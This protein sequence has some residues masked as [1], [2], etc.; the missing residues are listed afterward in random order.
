MMENTRQWQQFETVALSCV[1]TRKQRLQVRSRTGLQHSM[2]I[3]SEPLPP[4][5]PPSKG[6]TTIQNSG[7]VFKHIILGRGISSLN[8]MY[9]KEHFNRK[10]GALQEQVRDLSL[11]SWQTLLVVKL[12]CYQISQGCTSISHNTKPPTTFT[13]VHEELHPHT[14][15]LRCAQLQVKTYFLP[16]KS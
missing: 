10:T 14:E 3:H 16:K 5:G 13:L 1:L 12:F 9:L 11:A 8:Y 4:D 15:V 2:H 7:T 6:S